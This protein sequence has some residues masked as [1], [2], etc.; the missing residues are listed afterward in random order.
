MEREREREYL[1]QQVNEAFAEIGRIFYENYKNEPRPLPKYVGLFK[2]VKSLYE[3]LMK[4]DRQELEVQGLKRCPSCQNKTALESR[5][6]NM[7][8]YKFDSDNNQ[9]DELPVSPQ[10]KKCKVCGANMEDDSIFCG[11]CGH[12]R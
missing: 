1:M 12:K 11:N 8:G 5:F 9:Q 2:K 7:C 6:C 10:V 4:M 3:E